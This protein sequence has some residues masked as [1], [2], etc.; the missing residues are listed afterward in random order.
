MTRRATLTR[1]L[2]VGVLAG[3]AVLATVAPAA[4]HV[5]I[6]TVEPLGDGTARI[7][8]T[9]DHGCDGEPTDALRVTMP[10]GVEA[11]AADQPDD[12]TSELTPDAVAWEGEPVPDGDRAA[13]TVDVRATGE[14]G[15]AFVFVAEQECPSGASYTWD[16]TE[17]S[18]ERPAPTFVATA[19]T[20][21]PAAAA[22]VAA[23]ADPTPL[24][25]LVAGVVGASVLAGAGGAWAVRAR[26]AGQG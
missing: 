24:A 13:F 12:W 10:A 7:T 19:A 8:F 14:I 11:L 6:E 1:A 4:A 17:P 26:R 3:G 22:P 20:L 18:G 23:G 9:F 15:Q 5:L 2:A 25:P 16:D 21:S